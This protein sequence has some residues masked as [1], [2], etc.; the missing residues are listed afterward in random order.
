MA[1]YRIVQEGEHL[2]QIAKEMGFPDFQKIWNHPN[3][4]DLKNNR[5][6]PHILAPG[7]RL[8]IP[9]LEKKQENAPTEQRHNF[10]ISTA[11]LKLR[12]I[13]EDALEKPIAGAP[14]ALSVEDQVY[15]LTTDG[16]GKI[17]QD[18]PPDA[19][20]G[21]LVIRGDS[22]PFQD[23]SIPV[24]IGGLDPLDTDTG[25]KERLNNL[26]YFA[27]A[28]DDD[29]P[30]AFQSAVEEFQCDNGLTV[31]GKCGTNTQSKLKQI[32]GC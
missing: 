6:T 15:Q 16:N 21:C 2:A 9:D 25:Q 18:I 1:D 19:K 27:G 11:T 4:S 29:D 26:G 32:H 10:V 30:E 13:L 23:V 14:C 8:F 17:E 12:L 3:N 31:D 20:E 24:K 22:T 28:L 5:K 7:D